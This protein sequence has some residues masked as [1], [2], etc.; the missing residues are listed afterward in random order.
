LSGKVTGLFEN[1]ST[2]LPVFKKKVRKGCGTFRKMSG[3]AADNFKKSSGRELR[4]PE[5]ERLSC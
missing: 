5:K 4:I 2:M 1:S 3:S